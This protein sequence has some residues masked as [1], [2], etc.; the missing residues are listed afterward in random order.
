MMGA[1]AIWLSALEHH[2]YCPRQAALIHV[3]GLW[4][5]NRHTVRGKA[6]H[7]R[8]DQPAARYER[9]HRVFRAVPVWSER[10][11]LTGRCD[12]LEVH[13]NGDVVPVEY[14]IGSRHGMAADLQLCGQALCLE[15]M[16][17][18]S[19]PIGL[20][21]YSRPRRRDRVAIDGELRQATLVA[22]D[23]LRE[24]LESGVLPH[25]PADARCQSCQLA[26]TCLPEVVSNRHRLKGYLKDLY[27]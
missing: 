22:V 11:G 4:A 3:D 10:Y 23:A 25:A 9:G 2:G 27:R 16:L 26:P 15:E 20:V 21:W 19:I 14:K 24:V 5:D 17:D 1:D 18:I 13:L 6:G 7:R 12:A 8:A